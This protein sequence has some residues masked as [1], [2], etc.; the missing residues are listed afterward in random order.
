MQS[1][2][3]FPA[4]TSMPLFGSLLCA[5]F[6]AQDTTV[7]TDPLSPMESPAGLYPKIKHPAASYQGASSP[8]CRQHFPDCLSPFLTFCFS[9]HLGEFLEL[10]WWYRMRYRSKSIPLESPLLLPEQTPEGKIIWLFLT[11]SRLLL[12]NLF[13]LLFISWAIWP[14]FPVLADELINQSNRAVHIKYTAEAAVGCLLWAFYFSL[15]F[16]PL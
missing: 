12:A 6:R 3:S 13:M 9:F 16:Q 14:L 11:C 7:S 10:F 5:R 4:Q 2:V 8:M 15:M 1:L